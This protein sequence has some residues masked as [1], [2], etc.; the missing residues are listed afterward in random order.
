MNNILN[1]WN[2]CNLKFN[3][4]YTILLL[5]VNQGDKNAKKVME[6]IENNS[7]NNK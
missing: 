5:Q 2:T 3:D 6:L 7:Y 1:W 4:K